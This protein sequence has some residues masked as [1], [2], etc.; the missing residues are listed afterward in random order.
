MPI[1]VETDPLL[2]TQTRRGTGYY[3]VPSLKGLWYRGPFEHNGSVATPEDWF[4]P[5]R[6]KDD[7]VPTAFIGH[8][9][10]HRAVSGHN[11]GLD[12]SPDEKAR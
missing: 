12:L 6:V 4:N 5:A 1:S 8:R 9:V 11:F 2:A 7:Y 10:T 3:K